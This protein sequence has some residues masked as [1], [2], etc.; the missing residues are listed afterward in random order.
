MANHPA[1]GQME[2]VEELLRA[3]EERIITRITT[4]IAETNN[5]TN[6][7]SNNPQNNDAKALA[8]TLDS[9]ALQA[10]AL[11]YP[12]P[13]PNNNAITEGQ[14]PLTY[15][16]FRQLEADVSYAKRYCMVTHLLKRKRT[17][18]V[19][20]GARELSPPDTPRAQ[21]SASVLLEESNGNED[22]A[23]RITG[24][25]GIADKNVNPGRYG[26]RIV[27][28]MAKPH[29]FSSEEQAVVREWMTALMKATILRNYNDPVRSSCNVPTIPLAIA[30]LMNPAP[31]PPSLGAR[32]HP[33]SVPP[34][35]PESA[36]VARRTY[37]NGFT[38]KRPAAA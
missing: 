8:R 16:A 32:S 36:L 18:K 23:I 6:Q 30:Q 22:Q 21:G 13:L 27:H 33:T 4:R 12:L 31:R 24:Y 11:L 1:V 35:K 17:S 20:Q 25:K 34:R 38:R 3:M 14:F 26:F 7:L 10:N 9:S 2:R 28:D 19:L 5:R 29:F 37:F 15:G